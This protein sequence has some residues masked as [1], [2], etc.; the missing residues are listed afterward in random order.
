MPDI[1]VGW[2]ILIGGIISFVGCKVVRKF[3]DN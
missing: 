2:Y 1:G 3:R